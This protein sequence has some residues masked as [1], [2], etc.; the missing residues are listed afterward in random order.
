MVTARGTRDGGKREGEA[1]S[2]KGDGERAR[3]AQFLTLVF[4]I[5]LAAHSIRRYPCPLSSKGAKSLSSPQM[6]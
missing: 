1:G 6:A 5:A 4:H 2:G 3:V